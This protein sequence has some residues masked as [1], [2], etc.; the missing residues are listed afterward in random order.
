MYN[1][2]T[3]KM[4]LMCVMDTTGVMQCDGYDRCGILRVGLQV[5]STW[6]L[7]EVWS[8]LSYH[9]SSSRVVRFR[10]CNESARSPK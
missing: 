2:N 5:G 8:Y 4:R 6:M 10:F 1:N 3:R 9:S 7:L